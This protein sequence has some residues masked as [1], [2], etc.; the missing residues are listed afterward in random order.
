MKLSNRLVASVF[1]SVLLTGIIS[2]SGC[3]PVETVQRPSLNEVRS[4]KVRGALAEDTRLQP[5]EISAE[6]DQIDPARRE[7]GSSPMMVEGMFCATIS[8]ARE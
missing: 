3:V 2:L 7:L 8:I 1:S 5:G 6:I 4:G